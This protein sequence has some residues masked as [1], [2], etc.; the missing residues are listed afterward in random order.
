MEGLGISVEDRIKLT[1]E[2]EIII[3]CA[4]SVNFDDPLL[5]AIQINY[6]GVVRILNLAKESKHLLAMT[7]V[8][9]AYVNSNMSGNIEEKIYDLAGVEDVDEE[10]KRIQGLNPQYI[11]EN[12]MK[13][14]HGYKNTYTFTKSMSER[15][16]KKHSGHVKVAILRPSIVISTY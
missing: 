5:E 10:I 3:N 6:F 12:E 13:L 9:T 15:M 4:A 1:N 16:L 14:I 2:V 11:S 7:H 8:S